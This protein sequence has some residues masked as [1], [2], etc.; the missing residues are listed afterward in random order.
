MQLGP[1]LTAIKPGFWRIS[2]GRR[3]PLTLVTS[4]ME[5]TR[6]LRAVEKGSSPTFP[7]Q[8]L[9]G[10]ANMWQYVHNKFPEEKDNWKCSLQ[11]EYLT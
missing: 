11:W 10:C 9:R 5:Q 6:V 3:R 8:G 1:A 4:E 7:F 2:K